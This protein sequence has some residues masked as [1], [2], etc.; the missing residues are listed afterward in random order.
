MTVVTEGKEELK[1][2]TLAQG[3]AL[4][5]QKKWSML[6]KKPNQAQKS[7]AHHHESLLCPSSEINDLN[8]S[9]ASE[10]NYVYDAYKYN[11]KTPL[12]TRVDLQES[13]KQLFE[14]DFKLLLTPK[15]IQEQQQDWRTKNTAA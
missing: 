15:T 3:K 6:Q 10:Y 8:Q 12:D 13:T 7:E 1:P 4:E 2:Q 5:L 9:I 11:R 14:K